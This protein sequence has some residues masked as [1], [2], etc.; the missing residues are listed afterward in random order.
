MSTFYSLLGISKQALHQ[1][2]DRQLTRIEQEE[3]LM[4][5]ATA[6]RR[7]HPGMGCRT[8][9]HLVEDV[10]LGRDKAEAY[11]LSNGFRLKRKVNFIKTTI[12][13]SLYKFPN[14]IKGL[15]IQSINVVWQTDITYFMLPCGMVCYLIFIIDIYSRRILGYKANNHMR[16]EANL[17]C[18]KMAFRIRKDDSLAILIHHSDYGSQY[19]SKKYL[20][21]LRSRNIRISMCELAWQ[22]AYTERINGTIKNDYLKNRD[23]FTLHDLRKNLDIDVRAYNSERPHKN[24]PNRMSPFQFEAFLKNTPKS[25]HPILKVFNHDKYQKSSLSL[26]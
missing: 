4:K 18:L 8:L 17:E 7:R 12:R 23:I 3:R 6:I 5:Q 24:L 11:L 13:Q 16:S 10:G 19:V 26:T 9:Y 21:A 25:K 15:K 14:L 2:N 22:N 20:E 1:H